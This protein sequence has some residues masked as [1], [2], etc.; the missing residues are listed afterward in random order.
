MKH[1]GL[2]TAAKAAI[3]LL[4][5]SLLMFAQTQSSSVIQREKAIVLEQQ[6]KIAE[7]ENAWHT[8]L[9][10]QPES[11]EAYAH[12]GFLESRQERYSQAAS[13]YRK[14][15]SLDSA[16]PGL[17]MNLALALFKAGELRSALNVFESLLK[18]EPPSS[19]EAKRLRTLIGMSHYGLQ[20]YAAA[21]P[22]LK[23]TTSSD[24]QNLPVRLILAHSCLWTRKYQCVLDTYHEILLLN[25]ESAEADMLAG[26]ALD[27]MKDHAGATEQFRAA[28]KAN[29]KEPNVHFGLGYLLWTRG[30]Y[31]E[32]AEEFQAELTN[33]PNNAQAVA[34]L[35]DSKMKLNDPKAALPLLEKAIHIDPNVALAHVDLAAIYADLGRR[36]DALRELE[37]AAKLSPNDVKVHYRLARLYQAMGRKDEA[38][39][40]FEKTKTLNEA[41]DTSVFSQLNKGRA[42]SDS[43]HRAPGIVVDK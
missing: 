7:A 28:V 17:R 25:A 42:K 5:A 22:Y 33:I 31:Q 3:A 37:L 38:K 15:L 34:Y 36:N 29:P 13:L 21:I 18:K 11:A 9:K 8:F 43:S 35:A 14:A 16:I 19:A 27:E 6:G 30:Q 12:L 41:T 24:P 20:E 39:I 23:Q 26:E 1:I 40:E 10:S 32:A 2:L 4:A